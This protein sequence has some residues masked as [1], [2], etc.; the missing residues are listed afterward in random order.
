MKND[1]NSNN[2]ALVLHLIKSCE[3]FDLTEKESIE[4]INK[5]LD[6]GISR[7]AYYNYKKKLYDKE[8]IQKIKGSIY[9]TQTLR[10]LILDIEDTNIEKSLEADKMIAEQLP[11]RQ[12]IF[13][14]TAKQKKELENFN[15]E[16]KTMIAQFE[17]QINEPLQRYDGIPKNATV[18][19]ERVKCGKEFC[20]QC[21]HGPYYYAYW[22]DTITKKLR[23]K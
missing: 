12:D 17:N 9:D 11:N 10:C 14:D 1:K 6:K 22:R 5:V 3:N 18:K 20:L 2:S 8:V 15:E 21:P 19:E 7:R 16:T 23:K 13:H 4:T